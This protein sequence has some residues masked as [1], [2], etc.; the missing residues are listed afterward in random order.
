MA[1]WPVARLEVTEQA[2]LSATFTCSHPDSAGQRE[3]C[4]H[5]QATERERMLAWLAFGGAKAPGET[6]PY[7]IISAE[8]KRLEALSKHIA[9]VAETFSEHWPKGGKRGRGGVMS[10]EPARVYLIRAFLD[11][12]EVFF[13]E[14]GLRRILLTPKDF[15]VLLASFDNFATNRNYTHIQMK[16]NQKF[17]LYDNV[18]ARLRKLGVS[19]ADI[20]VRLKGAPRRG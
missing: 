10:D 18:S 6:Q 8:A 15:W 1:A 2:Y 17:P 4:P 11:L 16:R 14:K 13:R 20:P 12:I 7:E 9:Q 19:D 5:C 3:T